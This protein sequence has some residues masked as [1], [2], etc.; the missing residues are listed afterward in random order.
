M[1]AFHPLTISDCESVQSVTLNAGQRNCNYTFAN[2]LGYQFI[3]QTE[4]CVISDVVVVLR[5]MFKGNLEYMVCTVGELPFELIE[6]LIKDNHGKLT[7]RG[8][9]DSQVKSLEFFNTHYLISIERC[10]NQ[11]DYIY[12]RVD[13]ATLRGGHFKAKRNHINHF[14]AEYPAFEYRPLSP[15]LFEEC[16][17]LTSVWQEGKNVNETIAAECFAM[18]KVFSHWDALGMYGGSIFVEG[19]MAAFSYGA[20]V[21]NDT[22]DVCVEKAD[23]C[24]EGAFA[25]INQQ[26]AEHLPEQYIYINR[27]ED[28]GIRGLRKAKLSYHPEKLLSYNVVHFA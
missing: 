2:L 22:F 19:R 23:Y 15:E 11:Y 18:E 13:L 20:A 27:E 16:R 4:V 5:F 17:H 14:R 8:L 26:F 12:R 10:P 9:E 7:I 3:F 24:M 6:A 25:V 1:L 28:L 21:T